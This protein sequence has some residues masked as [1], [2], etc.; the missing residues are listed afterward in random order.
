MHPRTLIKV[1]VVLFFL[2][3]VGLVVTLRLEEALP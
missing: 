2:N 3:L 1:A